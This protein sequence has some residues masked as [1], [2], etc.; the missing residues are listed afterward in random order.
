MSRN[1]SAT[2]E[3]VLY[4]RVTQDERRQLQIMADREYEGNV[5]LLVRQL[6]RRALADGK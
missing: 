2:K 1:A 3:A 5:S 6:I 4:I